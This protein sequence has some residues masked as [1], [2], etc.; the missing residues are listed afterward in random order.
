M[1]VND[2]ICPLCL[3]Q[4]GQPCVDV[5]LGG[6]LQQGHAERQ[7]LARLGPCSHCGADVGEPCFQKRKGVLLFEHWSRM[8]CLAY[9]CDYCGALPGDLC[10]T[11]AGQV[12]GPH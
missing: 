5:A 9:S 2:A 1:N 7:N 6:E 12:R 4:P 10:N 11:P 8:E 3:A